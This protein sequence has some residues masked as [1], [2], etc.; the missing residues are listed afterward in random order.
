MQA[1]LWSFARVEW[2]ISYTSTL[3][4]VPIH[5]QRIASQIIHDELRPWW[6]VVLIYLAFSR[7]ER[8]TEASVH[9]AAAQRFLF[10]VNLVGFCVHCLRYINPLRASK[11]IL[12][13]KG[14]KNDIPSPVRY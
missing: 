9:E 5:V 6:E 11:T 13:K 4:Q 12:S 7:A 2:V 14:A 1:H 8:N 10:L 3:H